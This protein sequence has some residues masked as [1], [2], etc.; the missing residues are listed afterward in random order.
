MALYLLIHY[1]VKT[2]SEQGRYQIMAD[3]EGSGGA[4]AAVWAIALIVIVAIFAAVLFSSG[5]IGG[6]H[7]DIDV[8]IKAP[9]AAR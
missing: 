8:E 5:M 9:A 4:G 3:G 2:I 1:R 6:S 7:K